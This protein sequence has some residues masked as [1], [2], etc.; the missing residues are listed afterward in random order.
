MSKSSVLKNGHVVERKDSALYRR[1]SELVLSLKRKMTQD[2]VKL[3]PQDSA[4]WKISVFRRERIEP[5]TGGWM[6]WCWVSKKDGTLK[7]EISMPK[8]NALKKGIFLRG[9][10]KL[11][12]GW[13][14]S[15]CWVPKRMK[16]NKLISMPGPSALKNGHLLERKS[17]TL[18]RRVSELVLSPKGRW[19]REKEEWPQDRR[20][21]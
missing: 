6:R 5:F 3:V 20:R 11:F 16:Q 21:K 9:R 19:R 14:V 13:W 17:W 8:S 4:T 7:S 1:V 12:T 15:W 18:W 2:K 10:V